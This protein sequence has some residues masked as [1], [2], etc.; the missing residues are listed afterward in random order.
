MTKTRR[1][2][3]TPVVP[4]TGRNRGAVVKAVFLCVAYGEG[5]RGLA[6]GLHGRL[7]VRIRLGWPGAL[8]VRRTREDCIGKTGFPLKDKSQRPRFPTQSLSPFSV[9][10]TRANRSR[11][12]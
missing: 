5:K 10:Q 1:I 4:S 12:S 6:P 7:F 8:Y 11:S 9:R 2:L 3:P